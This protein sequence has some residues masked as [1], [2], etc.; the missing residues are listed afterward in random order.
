MNWRVKAL[1]QTAFSAIPGGASLNSLAQR[2]RG[3]TAELLGKTADR[4]EKSHWFIEQYRR[5]VGDLGQA[6]FFEFGAGRSLAGALCL[7]A[8]GVRRQTL[9]DIRNIVQLDLVNAVVDKLRSDLPD[10]CAQWP[11]LASLDDLEKNLGIRYIAPAD[12][13]STGLPSA[14]IDAMTST[15][16]MEHI[17][18]DDIRAI[19]RESRR[20]LK[21]GGLF[22]ALIDYQDHYSY[23]DRSITAYN[24]LTFNQTQW[25][26]YN[27][28]IHYQNRLRH[29]E[30]EALFREAGFETVEVSVN[31]GSDADRAVCA[32]LVVAPEFSRF[33]PEE[34]A[35]RKGKFVLRVSAG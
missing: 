19:L 24:F 33:T 25:R 22:L 27:S 9:V 11:T 23:R 18:P 31:A 21:P 26:L 16:T 10:P 17:P 5:Y 35:V 34:L 2:A 7:A 1:I 6:D 20:L 3:G 4:L 30:Y 14:S 12:A 13:R 8:A 15:Y 32:A 29:R 28:S